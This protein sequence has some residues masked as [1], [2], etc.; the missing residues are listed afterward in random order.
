MKCPICG[1]KRASCFSLVSAT[2]YAGMW[3]PELER[4]LDKAPSRF[5]ES[6]RYEKIMHA[7]EQKEKRFNAVLRRE[8]NK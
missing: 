4:A 7:V 8:Q 1:S 6:Q 5:T 2:R 3:C